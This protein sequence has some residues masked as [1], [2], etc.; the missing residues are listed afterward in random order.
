MSDLKILFALNK[1]FRKIVAVFFCITAVVTLSGCMIPYH[2]ETISEQVIGARADAGGKVYEQIVHREKQLDFIVLGLPELV[3]TADVRYSRYAVLTEDFERQ[4]YAME[5]FP[6]LAWTQVKLALPIPNSDR[7][8]V[9]EENGCRMDEYDI[10]LAIFSVSEG[11]I[12]RHRFK[13]VIRRFPKNS[14]VI[15]WLYIEANADMSWLRVHE[16]D[17]ITRI[18]TETGEMIEESDKLPPFVPA[19]FDYETL[20]K[21]NKKPLLNR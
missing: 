21:H 15:F 20:K 17:K 7:W 11:K 16:T 2:V 8:I 10:W 6:S 3:R 9:H 19:A 13:N 12:L 1:I 5:H 4:I 18:N 14:P